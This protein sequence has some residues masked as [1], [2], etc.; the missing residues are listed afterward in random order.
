MLIDDG[1]PPSALSPE[2]EMSVSAVQVEYRVF[3]STDRLL[4]ENF[5]MRWASACRVE[6]KRL[7]EC[8]E[9]SPVEESQWDHGKLK[10]DHGFD[11]VQLPRCRNPL[12]H[13]HNAGGE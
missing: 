13:E 3:S 9:L 10:M 8:R 12:P 6:S 1:L 2:F 4:L 7:T 5:Q 11:K